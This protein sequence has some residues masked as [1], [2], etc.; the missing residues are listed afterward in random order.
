MSTKSRTRSKTRLSRALGIALTPKAAR[1]L[2]KRPYA[3]GEHG[4]TKRKTDSDYAVRLREKQRLRAQY[5]IREAQL[6]I[7][8]NEARKASGLTGE[9]LVELLETR[10][11]ALVLRAGFA[12]TTAQA[13]Q[14]VV[15]RHILVDGKLVDRPSFRVKPGQMIH[16]KE[17]SEKTEPFQVAAAGGHVDLLPKVPGYLEV[18]IDKLQARLVRRPKRVEVPVTCEVQLVVEYYAAR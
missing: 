9:N 13:R 14:M 12:R 18:E 16:V 5:G 8:F 6:K 10:L 15:H 1:Y 17:R 4:R 3:P 11:D 2:E 7:V